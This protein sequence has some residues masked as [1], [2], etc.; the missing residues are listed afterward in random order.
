MGESNKALAFFPFKDWLLQPMS[1]A[2]RL[3]LCSGIPVELL[4]VGV[5]A[6]SDSFACFWD[7]F[8]LPGYL[9]QP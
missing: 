1:P 2:Y 4:T 7:H 8:L 5:G 3:W 6:V 9:I